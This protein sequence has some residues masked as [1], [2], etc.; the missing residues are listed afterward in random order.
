MPD[1]DGKYRVSQDQ[2]ESGDIPFIPPVYEGIR[3]KGTPPRDPFD[4]Q[5]DKNEGVTD[6]TSID[7]PEELF[8]KML[9]TLTADRQFVPEEQITE[10]LNPDLVKTF[11]NS[12]PFWTWSS[13]IEIY[14]C[15][16]CFEY[17]WYEVQEKDKSTDYD[18]DLGTDVTSYTIT[19][20]EHVEKICPGHVYNR[21]DIQLD[22]NPLINIPEE[23]YNMDR[24]WDM[25]WGTPKQG[26]T[27]EDADKRR[28]E[29]VKTQKEIEEQMLKDLEDYK[30]Q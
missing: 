16:G 1:E 24:V 11:F 2:H 7:I 6:A 29:G 28:E 5:W 19:A 26:E 12:L 3:W 25:L 9:A 10:H 4:K 30:N 20:V 22:S 18:E 8:V 14:Y 21:L 17:S 13:V 23:Y 15:E 27:Q